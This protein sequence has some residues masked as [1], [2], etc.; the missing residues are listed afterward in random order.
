M[1]LYAA[2]LDFTQVA[3]DHGVK[4]TFSAEVEAAARAAVPRT[5]PRRDATDLP[6]ITLD[7]AESMDLDQ[8]LALERRGEGFRV[9]YAIADVA[10][11][12]EPA[13]PVKDASMQRGQTIY[14]P[15]GPARLHPVALSEDAASLLPDELRPCVLWTVDLDA[16]GEVTSFHVERAEMRSRARFD[17]FE[18]QQAIE[19]GTA[20]PSYALLPEIG[21]LRATTS[22]RSSAITLRTLSQRVAV[23][24]GVAHL[25]LEPR[26]PVMDWNSELSL[27]AGMCAGT[28]MAS[29]GLGVLR[30]LPQP[31]ER[32]LERLAD[33]ASALGFPREVRLEDVD[34]DTP[35][36][37]A[38]MRDAQTL[39]RG[40]DY[41]ILGFGSGDG[42]RTEAASVDHGGSAGGEDAGGDASLT[43]AGVGGYYAHV[44]APLRRLVDRY[45]T[46]VCLHLCN[47][48]P[49]ESWVTEGIEQAVAAVRSSGKLAS[50][51]D[52][53][54]LE[55]TEATV[56]Q[57]WVGQD[58]EAVVLESRPEREH[59]KI[60]VEQ[61]PVI[62]KCLGA[63]K[64]GTRTTVRLVDTSD[65]EAVFRW[66]ANEQPTPGV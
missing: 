12:V 26:L 9:Y 30:T 44:T 52:R 28:L 64:E 23:H 51:V 56:L 19:A 24:D 55:L 6:L 2:E 46:E 25:E 17:Y 63:P 66:P 10:A 47:G 20:H 3:E 33:E 32:D 65:G 18:A 53:A 54:C 59:A 8:A 14:L 61:P 1:K 41:A 11:F 34:V 38:L 39:L 35:A 5:L 58:F 29:R 4:R 60:L 15:D 48:S 16:M 22:A 36:G 49:L 45:A 27:L 21:S 57:P 7:P 13:G 37:M 43:H 50:A 40:A 31:E 42:A 62:A